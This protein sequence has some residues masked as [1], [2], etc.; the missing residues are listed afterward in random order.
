LWLCAVA[1]GPQHPSV[2]GPTVFAHTSPVYVEVE[3]QPVRRAA[4]AVWLLDWLDR[5]EALV[6]TAG[7]FADDRQRDEVIAVIE[8]ARTYYRARAT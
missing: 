6:R 2:L 5:L 3:G 1:R 4:S 8:R 7:Q